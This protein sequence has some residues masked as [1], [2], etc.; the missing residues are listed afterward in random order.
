M[1][2]P[3]LGKSSPPSKVCGQARESQA[4]QRES[5]GFRH[6]SSRDVQNFDSQPG[7][8]RP[9]QLR[10]RV[11]LEVQRPKIISRAHVAKPVWPETSNPVSGVGLKPKGPTGA[12]TP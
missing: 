10:R 1:L 8:N 11:Q 7:Y 2:K 6:R 3:C 9:I 12:K 4:Q 5:A